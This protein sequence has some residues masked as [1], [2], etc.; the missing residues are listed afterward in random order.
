MTDHYENQQIWN[1]IKD[2]PVG[3]LTTYDGHRMHSR[4]MYVVQD[5]YEGTLWF[6]TH[7]GS[8]KTKNVFYQENVCVT[9]SNPDSGVQV[10]LSGDAK[11]NLDRSLINRFWSGAVETWLPGGK[12]DSKLGILEV[13]VNHAEYWGQGRVND[14]SD[15]TGAVSAEIA[16]EKY[17]LGRQAKLN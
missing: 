7:I 9:F 6:F 5:G 4:P 17:A 8:E 1:L 14:V 12:D 3:M 15:P 16:C 11:L 13:T 2:M 10:S